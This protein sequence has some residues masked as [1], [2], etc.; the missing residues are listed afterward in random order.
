[1]G[2]QISK[3]RET[4]ANAIAYKRG[5]R[6]AWYRYMK[7]G[8]NP[9]VHPSRSPWI[10]WFP[11]TGLKYAY[12]TDDLGAF[13]GDYSNVPFT[14][15][16]RQEAFAR[17]YREALAQLD[18]RARRFHPETRA[19]AQ[20]GNLSGDSAEDDSGEDEPPNRDVRSYTLNFWRA[21]SRRGDNKEVDGIEALMA[22]PPDWMPRYRGELPRQ[23]ASHR[24]P[25]VA[26]Q[27][28]G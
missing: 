7:A 13:A 2:L 23:A 8:A 26:K 20:D 16:A 14:L 4:K 5:V 28:P 6:L 21:N 18:A 3:A 11:G 9:R 27:I 1:M 22:R 10:V 19:L 15:T 25:R 17:G 12:M 24:S